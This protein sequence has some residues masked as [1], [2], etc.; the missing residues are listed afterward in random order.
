MTDCT[1]PRSSSR[2]M[3][4]ARPRCSSTARRRAAGVSSVEDNSVLSFHFVSEHLFEIGRGR[5]VEFSG[6]RYGQLVSFAFLANFHAIV[7]SELA[8]NVLADAQDVLSIL[9]LIFD[10]VGKLLDYVNA[11]TANSAN[12]C[13]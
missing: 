11:P 6:Q 10:F 3:D 5:R 12:C 13:G 7:P 4:W 8:L 2:M 1:R 9:A